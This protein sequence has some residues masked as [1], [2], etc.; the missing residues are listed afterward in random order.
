VLP[1]VGGPE[2]LSAVERRIGL[3]AQGPEAIERARERR[4]SRPQEEL[5]ARAER[6]D[7]LLNLFPHGQFEMARRVEELSSLRDDRGYPHERVG[8]Q[9]AGL[10]GL[11]PLPRIIRRPERE[12]L[13]RALASW[14]DR[15]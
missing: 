3:D 7:A 8:Q 1:A 11:G 2:P 9:R 5:A 10:D 12:L 4:S 15:A 14:A 6:L 13:E